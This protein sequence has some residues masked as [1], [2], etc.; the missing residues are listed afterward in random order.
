MGANNGE[1]EL[2]IWE[3]GA[4]K[5]EGGAQ[6]N[7]EIGGKFGGGAEVWG[8]SKLRGGHQKIEGGAP[9]NGGRFPSPPAS[10]KLK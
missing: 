2:R 1:F 9:K 5:I 8:G 3:G 7:G 6:K 4:P 10:Y